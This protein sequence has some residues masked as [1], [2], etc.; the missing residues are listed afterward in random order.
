[1][2]RAHI[3]ISGLVQGVCYRWF[4]QKEAGILGLTGYVKNLYDGRVEVVVEGEVGLI[5]EYLRELKTGPINADVRNINVEWQDYIGE[6]SGF[7]IRY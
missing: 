6:F 2:V 1:M 4:A 5:E 3:I 7:S